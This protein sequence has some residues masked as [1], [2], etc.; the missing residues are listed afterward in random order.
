MHGLTTL[1]CE[2]KGRDLCRYVQYFEDIAIVG[3]PVL[4]AVFSASKINVFFSRGVKLLGAARLVAWAEVAFDSGRGIFLE[5][6]A[7]RALDAF[8]FDLF[9]PFVERLVA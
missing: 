7:D 5:V 2:Q 3:R 9:A 6:S 8:A 1:V 4:L